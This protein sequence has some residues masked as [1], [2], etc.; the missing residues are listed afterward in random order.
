MKE[1]GIED[2]KEKLSMSQRV[3][4]ISHTNP[5][6]D[7]I[8]SSLGL[9]RI[10]ENG[11]H[12]VK[13]IFP[14][15]YPPILKFLTGIEDSIISVVQ[16]D[17][18]TQAINM[19]DVLFYLDFNGLDRIDQMGIVAQ[20]C[21][22]LKVMIDHHLDPEPIADWMLVDPRASST[23]ELVYV[24]AEMLGQL[25]NLDVT[26]ATALFTGILTDT[27]SFKYSTN[28]RVFRVASHLKEIGVNDYYLQNRLFNS[29]TEKQLRLIGHCIANRMELIREL[30]TGIIYLDRDD[31]REFRIKRGDTEGIVNYVLMMRHMRV[32]IFVTDQSGTIKLSF[33]S[34]GSVSVQGLA[35]EYF[36]GGGHKNA[37]GG[38]SKRNLEETLDYLKEILP[39]YLET[40]G[41]VN[42]TTT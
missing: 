7:A 35:R 2:V 38:S 3:T 8:G 1:V 34:K 24:F 19:A 17:E 33:R 32:A 14:T 31:F 36:G 29:L 10:L 37:S 20:E 12:S 16:T 4:I 28:P 40:Q 25:H 5:D 42:T 30:N 13:V 18:A 22:A 15:D 23:A 21:K 9:K 41:I 6:G 27:G 39:G 26:A 11:G